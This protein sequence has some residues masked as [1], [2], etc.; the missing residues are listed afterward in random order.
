MLCIFLTTNIYYKIKNKRF[1]GFKSFLL[2]RLVVSVLNWIK[3][4]KSLKKGVVLDLTRHSH[5]S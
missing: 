4:L 1:S 2:M 5:L 3:C